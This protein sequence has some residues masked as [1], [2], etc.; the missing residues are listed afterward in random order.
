MHL[1][2]QFLGLWHALILVPQFKDS[3]VSRLLSVISEAKSGRMRVVR[4]E[5]V[6][7]IV[8]AFHHHELDRFVKRGRLS[9]FHAFTG[10]LG[11]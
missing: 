7:Q 11:T 2:D 8:Q 4:I 1:A 10:S 9:I 3:L 6:H 5:R